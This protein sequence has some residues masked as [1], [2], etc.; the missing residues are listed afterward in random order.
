MLILGSTVSGGASSLEA[1]RAAALGFTV[2]VDSNAAWGARSTAD[3]ATFKAI[4]FGDATCS[5][6]L[7]SVAAATANKAVWGPAITGN[8]VV[9]GTDPTFHQSRGGSAVTEKGIAFAADEPGA[10]GAYITLSCYYFAAASMTP[11]PLLDPFGSFTVRGV[12][13]YDD[14]HIVATHP[15][16]AGLTDANLSNWS[17]SVHEV[18]DSFPSDF[19]PLAIAEGIGGSGSLAFPDGSFGIPYIVARG[20]E[21]APVLCGNGD[22][23]SG[24]ECD[25]GNNTNGDGCSVTCQSEDTDGDGFTVAQ[26]DCNDNN[27]AINPGATEVCNGVDDDCDGEIDE[28]APLQPLTQSCYSGPANTAGIGLCKAGTQT[29]T[30]G[31]FGTCVGE[32]TPTTEVCDGQ[33]NNCD[34]QTDEGVQTTF[35]RDGDS[36]GFG[37]AADSTQA[38]T[39]PAGFVTDNIDCN[40]ANTATHPGATEVCDGLDNDCDGQIDESVQT[41]FYQDSDSDGF[42]NL[43]VTLQACTVPAGYIA[44]STD[45]NDANTAIHPGAAE[46]CNGA[47]DNCNGQTDEGVQSTFYHDGDSDGFGNLA[48]STQACIAPAGFVTNSTDCNDANTSIHPGATEACN[49]GDDDCDGAADETFNVGTA[50]SVG[51]GVCQTSGTFMCTLDGQGTECSALPGT[52]SSEVCN[53]SD[54]DCDNEIDEATPGQ[55]LTQACYSGPAGTAGIGECHGGTQT[56]TN[57]N[58]GSCVGQVTPMAELCD[59]KDNN[60][61]GRNDIVGTNGIDVLTGTPGN[62]VIVGLGGNDVLNGLGGNDLLCGGPGLDILLGGAGT[63]TLD[64]GPGID[65]CNGGIGSDTAVNCEVRLLVP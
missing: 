5:T 14:A 57:G 54:D 13:G 17:A 61:D 26:G 38:C 28:A 22:L 25:D 52:P 39:A 1:T 55:P 59:G 24:E 53:G 48:D 11:V 41:T 40:D 7:A 29:C 18:F 2:V 56:C 62:D 9:I 33:D 65:T 34:G 44:N 31:S 12:S 35:Y 36:D 49:G 42:G 32:V 47:D 30:G 23:D 3:F 20:K 63:D 60:C 6:S 21:L 19:L 51:V 4:I 8:V 64:G 50:C 10:T 15:A 27:A 46:V 45:C 58:F 16:L 37:N 43:A